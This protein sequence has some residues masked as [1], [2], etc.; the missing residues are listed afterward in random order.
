MDCVVYIIRII[1]LLNKISNEMS[2]NMFEKL[3]L[4]FPKKHVHTIQSE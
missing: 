4:Y 1:E 2:K 3:L